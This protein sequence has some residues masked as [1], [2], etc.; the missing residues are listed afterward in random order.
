MASN[1]DICT[2]EQELIE[3]L[4]YQELYESMSAA[5]GYDNLEN[6]LAFIA[7]TH[8]VELSVELQER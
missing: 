6:Y 5:L 2:A 4:G 3:A 1:I 8:E 7:R